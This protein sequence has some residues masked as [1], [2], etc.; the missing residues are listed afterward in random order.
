[1]RLRDLS[2]PPPPSYVLPCKLKRSSHCSVLGFG[3]QQPLLLKVIN[4]SLGPTP[5]SV[6]TPIQGK[7]FITEWT[8]LLEVKAGNTVGEGRL[9]MRHT[10]ALGSP[11]PLALTS[12][13]LAFQRCVL[14]LILV[15]IPTGRGIQNLK[16]KI[17]VCL[18][19]VL[20]CVCS[21]SCH[22]SLTLSQ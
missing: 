8:E 13:P 19:W 6:L 21:F 5:V 17:E 11:L 18:L 10:L 2:S 12:L 9:W 14:F 20:V 1:M 16:K 3:A 7:P 22:S 4:G 15:W